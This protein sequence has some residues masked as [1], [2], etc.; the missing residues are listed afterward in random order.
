MR[1]D[2]IVQ[3]NNDTFLNK[4]VEI[5]RQHHSHIRP[6]AAASDFR[7]DGVARLSVRAS[8]HWVD[9]D[10]GVLRMNWSAY[11]W[12]MALM[13]RQPPLDNRNQS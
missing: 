11:S 12:M 9:A 3:G 10:A 6:L 5:G 4:A 2:V 8:V 7:V 13:E 1:G